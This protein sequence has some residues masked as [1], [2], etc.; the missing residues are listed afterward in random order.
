MRPRPSKYYPPGQAKASERILP[1]QS[2]SHQGKEGF[3]LLEVI[4]AVAIASGVLVGI[5]LFYRQT[6]DLRVQLL[7]E[8]ERLTA[9]RLLLDRISADLRT[10]HVDYEFG[11]GLKGDIA[12]LQL[13]KLELPSRSA[14][15]RTELGASLPVQS[16][17]RLVSYSARSTLEDGTN[18]VMS[19]LVRSERSFLQPRV[20]SDSE[21]TT[22]APGSP[23]AQSREPEQFVD[24]VRFIQFRFWDGTGWLDSWGGTELPQGVEVSL[25]MEPL[26]PDLLPEEY[27]FELFRRVIYL[28][29]YYPESSSGVSATTEIGSETGGMP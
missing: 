20:L 29:G 16:D 25:G 3:T 19:G 9:I 5:L 22:N 8:T 11:Q 12:S 17:L 24:A 6:A 21:S 27:P 28:P 18:A 1:G 23:S 14:W 13:L 7:S 2:S 4:L 26:P 15:A 10:A